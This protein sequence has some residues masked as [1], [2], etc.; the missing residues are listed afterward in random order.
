M[1]PPPC[2][3][4][5]LLQLPVLCIPSPLTKQHALYQLEK[6]QRHLKNPKS[7]IFLVFFPIEEN[8]LFIFLVPPYPQKTLSLSSN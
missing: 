2:Q 8:S 7:N 5:G 3:S 1:S 4:L 6:N